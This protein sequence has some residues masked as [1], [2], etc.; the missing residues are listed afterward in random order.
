MDPVPGYRATLEKMDWVGRL[1]GGEQRRHRL[2]GTTPRS[3]G[4]LILQFRTVLTKRLLARSLDSIVKRY[5]APEPALGSV[6]IKPFPFGMKSWDFG[7]GLHNVGG[8]DHKMTI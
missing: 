3:S 5:H 8:I 6:M 7:Q 1:G 2:Q 4:L